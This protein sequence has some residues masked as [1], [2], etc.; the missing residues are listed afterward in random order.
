MTGIPGD[1]S[2]AGLGTGNNSNLREA[3]TA[4]VEGPI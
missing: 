3:L 4:E 1:C 2:Q